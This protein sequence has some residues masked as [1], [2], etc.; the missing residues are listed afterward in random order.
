LRLV[1]SHLHIASYFYYLAQCV[2]LCSLT[3][4]YK[5]Y[6]ALYPAFTHYVRRLMPKSALLQC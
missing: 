1:A 2:P 4:P 6:A 5:A 3:H